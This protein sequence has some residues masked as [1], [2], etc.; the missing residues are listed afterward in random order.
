MGAV[1]QMTRTSKQFATG[2]M[3]VVT[4]SLVASTMM[5]A[6]GAPVAREAQPSNT[7]R[8]SLEPLNNSGVKGQADVVVVDG[9]KVR[10]DL[11]ARRLL[12]GVPHAQHIHFG[13]RARH[14]CPTVRD[15][16]NADHRLNTVEGQPAYGPVKVS[17][18][19]RGDTSPDS[20]LAV[21]RFPTAPEGKV[22]YDRKG[23]KVSK[24]VARAIRRGNAVVVVHGIDYNGNGTYDFE[25]G[26]SEL[27][28][29]LPAEATDPVSCGVLRPV[30]TEGDSGP[31]PLP[32]SGRN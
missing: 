31:L 14:E 24:K 8:A 4:G 9:R 22:N 20:T 17:L 7:T 27:D 21:N 28:P 25:A 15:D 5:S 18:T 3:L 10:V 30:A 6:N 13:G 16:D 29:S 32:R 2:T 11:N 26:T 12:K 23:I 19:T 1:M